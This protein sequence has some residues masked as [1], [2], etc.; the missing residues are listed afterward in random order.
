MLPVRKYV[1]DG[2]NAVGAARAA[3]VHDGGVG[4]DPDPAA[5]LGQPSVVTAARLALVQH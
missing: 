1:V 2:D 3:V 5:G 4:L